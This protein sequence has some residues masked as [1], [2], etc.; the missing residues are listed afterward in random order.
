M[1]DLPPDHPRR[2]PLVRGWIRCT[3]EDELAVWVPVHNIACIRAN[4]RG[5]CIAL[6]ALSDGSD[7]DADL[8][9]SQSPDEVARRIAQSQ[10]QPHLSAVA[11]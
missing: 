9:V 4:G 8:Y 6:V 2:P 11:A 7:E 1:P 10:A 3:D 5:A